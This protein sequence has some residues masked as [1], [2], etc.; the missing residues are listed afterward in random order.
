MHKKTDSQSKELHFLLAYCAEI[1]NKGL[2]PPEENK[3]KT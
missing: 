2:I 1:C 3:T